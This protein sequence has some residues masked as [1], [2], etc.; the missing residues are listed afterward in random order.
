MT[1]QKYRSN[2]VPG[3]TRWALRKAQW[4]AL[5]LSDADMEKPKIAVVN[6]SSELSSCFSHLDGVA[7]QVKAAIRAAGGVPFEVRTAAP[8]DF[9]TSAGKQ[10][11][12]ILPSRD[13]IVNDIEV[14]VEGAQLDGMVCLASCDKTTPGQMMAAARLNIPTIVVICGYQASGQY[15]GEHVD[16]EDVFEKVG[17]HV[18]GQLSF[19]DLDGMCKRA[20]RSPGVCAGLGTANSMH[21]VCEALGLTLPGASPVL[22]NSPAMVEQARAAGARIVEMVE[23]G[24]TPRSILTP[25]AFRNAVRVA[26]A[27]STSINVLRHLQGVAE[28]AGTDVDLYDLF[29]RLG[30][31]VPLLATVKPN[32]PHR[33]EELE[34]AGGTLATI[35]RLAPMIEQDCL[36]VSGK[37]WSAILDAY[38]APS[39]SILHTL[40][41][42]VSTKPSL[43]ILKGSLAPEGSI[44]KLGNAGEKA[45]RFRGKAMVFHSQEEAIAALAD[46]KITAGTVACLRGMGPIGGP[47]VALA[48]SFVAAVEGAGFNGKVAVV[49]DGQLSGLNRGVAVGQVCPEAAAG[50]PLALVQ[51]G[52]DIEIDIPGRQI[53]LLVDERE[54][55]ARQ[56]R[57]VPILGATEQGWL[58]IYSKTVKPLARGAVLIPIHP[59]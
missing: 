28:E 31:E 40:D 34:A 52:D 33:T 9:I 2:F 10:G 55:A 24:L 53:N 36:T 54:M 41:D 29:D 23:A 11:R 18:T 38:E 59:R 32:G 50:G 21:I 48:S 15:K 42:P 14:Q 5:G 16:I 1:S 47:G 46:G 43:V 49:T 30:R 35:K 27:L 51:D 44:L 12:Y 7:V 57:A 56:A 39:P 13:L 4:Q 20:V 8:S 25:G 17:M 3:T 26:L 37:T 19:E 58:N 45:E 22:A 6:T